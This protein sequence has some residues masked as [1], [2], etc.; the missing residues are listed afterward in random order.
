MMNFLL[1]Y[2]RLIDFLIIRRY[3]WSHSYVW[4]PK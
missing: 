2:A 1:M 4:K 3:F